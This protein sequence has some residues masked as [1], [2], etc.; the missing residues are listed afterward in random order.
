MWADTPPVM[1]TVAHQD[2]LCQINEQKGTALFMNRTRLFELERPVEL[3]A[4]QN[5][6]GLQGFSETHVVTKNSMQLVLVQKH[7]PL[8]RYKIKLRNYKHFNKH[9]SQLVDMIEDQPSH[10]DK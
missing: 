1:A 2:V 5:A 10:D 8:Y 4:G 7:H 9:S 6:N 3:V